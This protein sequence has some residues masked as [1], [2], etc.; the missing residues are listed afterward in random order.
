MVH[1]WGGGGGASVG[2]RRWR[3]IGVSAVEGHWWWRGIGSGAGTSANAD[4]LLGLRRSA[5]VTWLNLRCLA[6]TAWLGRMFCGIFVAWLLAAQCPCCGRCGRA[7]AEVLRRCWGGIVGLAL[8]GYGSKMAPSMDEC[9]RPV[10]RLTSRMEETQNLT[11]QSCVFSLRHQKS[12]GDLH[13][14]SSLSLTFL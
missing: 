14:N 2:Q 12:D 3:I 4:A 8:A 10:R 6:C 1:L 7:A 11:S 5:C 13:K 9:S